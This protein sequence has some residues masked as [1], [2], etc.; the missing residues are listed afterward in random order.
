M[1]LHSFFLFQTSDFVNIFYNVKFFYLYLSQNQYITTMALEPLKFKIAIERQNLEKELKDTRTA[2]SNGLKDVP[3]TVKIAN[4][5]AIKRQLEGLE[6]KISS[7]GSSS[8]KKEVETLK[9]AVTQAGK[10]LEIQNKVNEAMNKMGGLQQSVKLADGFKDAQAQLNAFKEKLDAVSGK[11]A[12]AAAVKEWSELSKSIS[13]VVKEQERLNKATDKD[14]AG[15]AKSV[16]NAKKV[17]AEIDVL[18][19]KLKAKKN[20]ADGFVNTEA[21]QKQIAALEAFRTEAKNVADGVTKVMGFGKSGD[22]AAQMTHARAELQKLEQEINAKKKADAD[23]EKEAKKHAEAMEKQAKAAQQLSAEEQKLAQAIQQSISQ[24]NHQSQVLTDLK[25]MAMQYLSVYAG[26]QFLNNIIEIGGQ[27]EMQRLSI[28]AILQDTAHANDLFERIKG[29]A[30]QSPFGV[31]E[32]DQYTKQLSAYGFQYNELFDMTKRLADI[33]AGAGTDVSRLALALGHVRAEGALTGYTLRQFAMNNIPMLGKLS[34]KLSEL[35]GRIVT[36]GEVRKRVRNKDIDYAMV[37]SVIKDLTNE[38]GMFY[39]MQE[40]ISGSVKAK[41]KNLRDA[42]DIMYGEMAES[43]V[44]GVLK[45]TATL[46]TGLAKQWKT[47]GTVIAAVGGVY[48]VAKVSMLAYN[49]LLGQQTKAVL[50]TIAAQRQ[51]RASNLQVISSYRTLTTAEQARLLTSTKVSVADRLR[52]VANTQSAFAIRERIALTQKARI[53]ELAMAITTRQLTTEELARAV[54]LGKVNKSVALLA[55]GES[56]L[57]LAQQQAMGKTVASVRT[58]GMLTGVVNGTAMAFTRLGMAIKGLLLNPA[59]WIFA[60]ISGITYLW[61]KNNEEMERAAGLSKSLAERASEG[62]KNVRTMMGETGMTYTKDGQPV[63]FGKVSGGTIG[64]TPA[65]QM[66]GDAMIQTMEKWETFI[67]NYSSM[68]NTLLQNAFFDGDKLRDLTDQYNN[69]AKATESVMKA[70]EALALIADGSEFIEKSTQTEKLWGIFDDDL[71]TN[72]NEYAK[73]VRKANGVLSKFASSYRGA[74]VAALNAAKSN[75]TFADG[76]AYANSK[77]MEKEGRNLTEE[78]QLKHLA[79]YCDS[80]T[81]A[82]RAAEQ[83]IGNLGDKGAMKAFSSVLGAERNENISEVTMTKDMEVAGDAIRQVV[84]EKWHKDISELEEFEKQALLQMVSDI[85]AKSNES[86][87]VI[88]QHI[89][90]LFANVLKIPI[91]ADAVDA[92]MTISQ[93]EQELNNLVKGPN[94]KDGWMIDIKGA[95]EANDIVQKVREAYKKAQDTI[96]NLGPIAIKMGLSLGKVKI[97]SEDEINKAAGDSAIRRMA[98]MA[99]N[100]AYKEIAQAEQASNTYGFDLVDHTKSGKVFKAGKDKTGNKS[101]SKEDKEA[102]EW[103]ERI[104]LLKDARS[105]YDKWEKE[106]GHTA[107]LERVQ[108]QFKNLVNPKDIETLEAYEKALDAVIAKAQARK[109]KNGGKD[110]RA[111]EVIRQGDD[112]KAQIAMLKFQRDS[113][114]YASQMDKDMERLTRQWEIFNNV[115]EATGDRMLAIKMSG[116]MGAANGE[117]NAADTLKGTIAGMPG[118]G[119]INFASVMGM[120]GDEIDKYVKNLLGGSAEYSQH[121]DAITKGLK[122]WQKLSE[123]AMRQDIQNYAKLIGSAKDYWSLMQKN[124]SEYDET[125]KMLFANFAAG[126]IDMFGLMKGLGMAN[127]ER[128][129]KNSKLSANYINLMNNANALTRGEMLDAVANA[130]MHLNERMAAGTITV[131]EYVNEL[132]K[133]DDI[134][135]EWETNGFFGEKGAFGSLLMGGTKG[136]SDYYSSREQRYRT[137]AAEARQK[138]GENSPEAVAA[139]QQA[140]KYEK[141]RENLEKLDDATQDIVKAFET[142]KSGVDLVGNLFS[143]LGMEG[144]ANTIGSA[145]NIMGGALSGASSLSA[146]GPYGMAAGAA[147]GG[148][149]AIIQEGDKRKERKIQE[150][151]DEVSKI[152]NTINL[153]NTGRER[154]LGYDSG[155]YRRMMAENYKIS[156]PQHWW[157][158]LISP[159][160]AGNLAMNEYYTRGGL[161]GSG[162]TQELNALKKQREDYLKM[163]DTEESKKDES[164]EALE[165]YKVKI[166]ELDDKIMYYTEDLAKELWSIDLK[167]WADQIGDALMNAFEN[168]TSAANAFNDAVSSIMKSVVSEM[169][170]VGFMQ[171]M[172]EQLRERLFGP[173]GTFDYN[174]PKASMGAT[175]A[176]LGRFF[177]QDGEGSKMMTA[178]SEFLSGAEQL[179]NENYGLSLKNSS[180]S[181]QTSGIQSQ[182]TEESVGIL[183]GQVARMAQDI[184]VKRIFVTQIA[185]EQMPKLLENAQMQRTLL[186][187][188]FQS[189]RAIEHM[190]ADGDG[191]MYTAIDR[192]SRKIDRAITPEGRMRVE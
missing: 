93:V 127:A 156:T 152:N 137:E 131:E 33:S 181:T 123:N 59:T 113:E 126:T 10:L 57:A 58:Y 19:D 164:K 70:Q 78:E 144:A 44:G 53:S 96:T 151:K 145:S 103:R 4:L 40:V 149:T 155:S 173:N 134:R 80:Y 108:E 95:V 7:S 154:T 139:V 38:G 75:K 185:T 97:M 18:L 83:A 20:Q 117:R 179:L 9:D 146:L 1:R 171:P 2:I 73:D 67:K 100:N 99:I 8:Q 84:K 124:N 119:L 147:I 55:I 129:D 165:E 160:S 170:K 66:D 150:L 109:N 65:S 87:E 68:P 125:E 180:Q 62:L 140:D 174:D 30:L 77:M 162:Y 189:V 141:M 47:I 142:L 192:M 148:L 35:E 121:I 110:E 130:V 28:G 31:V 48:G 69:L 168:G 122:E 29:L 46:L 23:A 86:T 188:Q 90:E 37:E 21:I 25:S 89:I 27:L 94:G 143:A 74:M 115:L 82:V 88:R 45:G 5:D 128:N 104:R 163:Y 169:L 178:A 3:I 186:E 101:G 60:L 176:E 182:A 135:S 158:W 118:G 116:L 32:L 51:A 54:A 92:H 184:S 61:Q 112:E 111:D 17:L 191:A 177:G 42:F 105:W 138:Y 120:H 11:E 190:M 81:E 26:Q 107:A 167:G 136:L 172:M 132:K 24:M 50:G 98:L 41:W 15:Y 133:L 49:A 56:K 52:M 166:A 16:E 85:A 187:N 106:I 175:L 183:S 63:E 72:M 76:L 91:D 34:E 36:A 13:Q 14:N 64:Y 102:K 6:V 161:G 39:N 71:I 43:A 12:I 114:A 79:Y 157:E 22:L 153:I 159:N